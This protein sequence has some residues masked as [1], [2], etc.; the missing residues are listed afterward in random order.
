MFARDA[1]IGENSLQQDLRIHV[2]MKS[3]W[4]V[5]AWP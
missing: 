3:I 2:G 4:V 1:I 5:L